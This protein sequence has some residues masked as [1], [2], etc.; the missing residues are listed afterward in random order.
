MAGR[1]RTIKPE[2]LT[3]A[4]VARLSDAAWRLF[5]ASFVLADDLGRFP[6]DPVIVGGQVFPGRALSEV[7]RALTEVSR[8]GFFTLYRVNGEDYAEIRNFLK[9]QKINRPSGPKFPAPS[10]GI[11]EPSVSPH[12][13]LYADLDHD[14]DHDLYPEGAGAPLPE[15]TGRHR[16]QPS[17]DHAGFIAAFDELYAKANAGARPTW[18]GKRG[19]QVATLLKAHGLDECLKRATNMFQAP[20]EWPPPPHDLG[21]LVQHF[22]RFAQPHKAAGGHFK[23]T[24]DEVYAGGEVDL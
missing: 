2:L 19:K 17:G 6:A 14:H 4:K 16:K 7:S 13:G 1:I 21:T 3:D 24:G 11:T 15:G 12:G 22:D 10:D 8:A 23:V 9:H 18:D 20:P 5:V